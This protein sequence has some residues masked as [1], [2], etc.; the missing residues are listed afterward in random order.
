M[1]IVIIGAGILGLGHAWAAA[2]RGHQVTVLERTAR[3]EGASIRNF[4]MVWPIGQPPGLKLATALRSRELWLEFI[5]ASGTFHT[6]TG[7]IH[8]VTQPD[9]LAVIE[10]FATQGSSLGYSGKLLS[11]AEALQMGPAARADTVIGG[12]FSP[13][14]VGVDP[15]Q[16]LR[17][18]AAWLI[19]SQGV[20]I[21]WKL[22]AVE[23]ADGWVRGADR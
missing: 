21:R 20:T 10:E 15:P 18:L 12:F 23:V 22:P 7:S 4:G 6:S 3:A 19:E 17:D 13:T 9:E 16:A 8:L 2:R 11:R 14:E 1:K 5:K